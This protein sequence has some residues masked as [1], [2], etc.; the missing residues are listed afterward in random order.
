MGS[1]S[2]SQF[3]LAARQE[4]TAHVASGYHI[5]QHRSIT[6]RSPY[7]SV[8]HHWIRTSCPT[9]A[10]KLKRKM[11]QIKSQITRKLHIFLVQG[12]IK[13]EVIHQLQSSVQQS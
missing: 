12:Q 11:L 4:L 3:G 5:A 6:S 13:K 10:I 9:P 2:S 1:S 8:V 7:H